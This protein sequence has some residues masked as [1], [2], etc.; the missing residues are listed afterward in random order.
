MIYSDF[1]RMPP[2]FNDKDFEYGYSFLPPKDWY[3][4]PVYP[5]VC[6]SDKTCLVQPSYTD[7]VTMDLKEWYQAQ[8]FTPPDSFNTAFLTNEMN[9]KN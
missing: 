6:V 4:L 8:K 7:T 9:S 3:P 2:S 5:P 1:N